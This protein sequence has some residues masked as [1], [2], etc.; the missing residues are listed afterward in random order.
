MF[1]LTPFVQDVIVTA[2]A[3][4]ALVLLVWR[5]VGL[6]RPAKG[7]AACAACP[8]CETAR[9]TAGRPHAETVVPLSSVK[10][11]KAG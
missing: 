9:Q 3:F 8:N 11:V 4:G 7:D 6:I 1:M 5:T 2:L 10:R